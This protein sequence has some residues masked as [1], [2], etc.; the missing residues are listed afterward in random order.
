METVLKD[1]YVQK[2]EIGSGAYGRVYLAED[3]INKKNVAIKRLKRSEIDKDEYL[4]KA[5][6]KE[7]EIMKLCHC[8]N[9][10]ILIEDFQ[11]TN[12]YNF[13][14]EL[15]DGDLDGELKSRKKPFTEEELKLILR[16]LSNVFVIMD[17]ENIIHRDIKHKN[18]LVKKDPN[19]PNNKL[20]FIVKIADFGF[21]KVMENDMTRSVLGTPSTMAP[22]VL[23]KSEYSKKADLWSVGVITYQLLFNSLPFN[24]RS[25]EEILQ[26]ILKSKEIMYP[27]TNPISRT[28]KHLINNLLQKDPNKRYNWKEFLNHPFLGLNT[29]IEKINLQ[30]QIPFANVINPNIYINIVLYI[31]HLILLLLINS[32]SSKIN[33][34]EQENYQR[35]Q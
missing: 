10:V 19:N 8:E 12:N 35:T 26:T 28:L 21:S 29:E 6:D 11:T 34:M 4:K 20:G 3:I 14:M 33:T 17:R 9:S 31:I 18:F 27:N 1:Q 22:E 24:G 25:Q 5:L 15:C 16:Q 23:S 30:G 32:I 13:V 2:K 7:I